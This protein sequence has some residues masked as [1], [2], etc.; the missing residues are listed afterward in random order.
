V[1]KCSREDRKVRSAA[2]LLSCART[3]ISDVSVPWAALMSTNLN[4][5]MERE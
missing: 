4:E 2:G 3:D 1:S 5:R